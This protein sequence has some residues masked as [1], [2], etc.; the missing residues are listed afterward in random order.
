MNLLG[1]GTDAGILNKLFSRF[2]R[3]LIKFAGSTTPSQGSFVG[4]GGQDGFNCDLL[5]NS[6]S[7]RLWPLESLLAQISLPE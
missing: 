1:L 3:S 5:M 7:L 4:I 2:L 6:E